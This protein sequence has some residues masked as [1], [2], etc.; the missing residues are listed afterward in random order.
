MQNPDLATFIQSHDV[1]L[2]DESAL[3]EEAFWKIYKDSLQEIPQKTKKKIGVPKD[4]L[5]RINDQRLD[6]ARYQKAYN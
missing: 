1:L 6:D 2:I 4:V 3:V 5:E